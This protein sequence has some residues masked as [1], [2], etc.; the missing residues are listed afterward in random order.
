[1][2]SHIDFLSTL[3]SFLGFDID[4]LE[5]Q[6]FRGVD[7]SK[8]VDY[9][10]SHKDMKGAPDAQEVLLYTYDDFYAGQDPSLSAN[11]EHGLLPAANRI[12]ALRSKDFKLVRYYSGDKSCIPANWEE[13]FYDLRATGGDYY[14]NRDPITGQL[15][16][17]YAAPLELVNLAP[18]AD[19]QRILDGKSAVANPFQI[20]ACNKMSLLL[21][22]QIADRLNPLPSQP[23][24]KPSVFVYQG[25]SMDGAVYQDG[26]NVSRLIQG[27]DSQ[28]LELAFNTRVNQ[29]Y[30]IVYKSADRAP[31]TLLSGIAGTNGPVL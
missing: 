13:E 15:N 21:D 26:D 8:I 24:V 17:F 30:N 28:T 14:P 3:A 11:V 18:K 5:K 10:H 9:A 4:Y 12:H 20:E 7:Y 23:A 1:M 31:V 19:L 27:Q 2:I 25:G 22:Q 16:P 6:G 29:S